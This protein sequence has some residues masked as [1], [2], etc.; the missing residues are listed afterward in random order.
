[1]AI[2][3]AELDAMNASYK[4]AVENWIRAIREEEALASPAEH[5]EAQIDQWEAAGNTEE[6]A[7][8]QAK[9]AKA[10]YESALREEFFSF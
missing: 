6:A 5:G 7:R 8:N 3:Q 1:V 9:A 4:S 2:E 10:A